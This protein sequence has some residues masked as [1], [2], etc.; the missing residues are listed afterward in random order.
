MSEA[1]VYSKVNDDLFA[2]PFADLP[3]PTSKKSQTKITEVKDGITP[4]TFPLALLIGLVVGVATHCI[5][6]HFTTN[7]HTAFF[8]GVGAGA[9]AFGLAIGYASCSVR[10]Y[11]DAKAE[12]PKDFLINTHGKPVG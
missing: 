8:S 1:S 9:V 5:A 7:A 12:E 11:L 6:A 4:S 2:N 10:K 3:F